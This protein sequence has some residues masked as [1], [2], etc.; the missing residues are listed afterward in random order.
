MKLAKVR[1]RVVATI[2]DNII[3]FTFM[4]VTLIGIWPG[5]IYAL[6]TDMTINLLMLLKIVRAGMV[7]ALFLL[8]YYMVV[9]IFLKGQSIGKWFFK[10]KIVDED[11]KDVDYKVLFFREA[12]CRILVR[13]L[14]LGISSVV[15]FI[16]MIIRDDK[17]SIADVFAKTKVI[18][19]KEE[20]IWQ[21]HIMEQK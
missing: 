4:A 17:K 21:Q 9:P 6:F 18:D 19:I 11:G 3:I 15:S 12:I 10:L 5:F 7:Y 14:S 16:L 13:T 8:F 1:H 2:L 20:V